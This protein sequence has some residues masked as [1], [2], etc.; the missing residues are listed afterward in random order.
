M[1]VSDEEFRGAEKALDAKRIAATMAR[2]GATHAAML[3]AEL[4]TE[5]AKLEREVREHNWEVEKAVERIAFLKA[6]AAAILPEPCGACDGHGKIRHWVAQDE[7]HVRDCESCK[8]SGF[9]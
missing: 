7:S 4:R 5:V 9:K 2:L 6:A 8:G 1:P 3:A